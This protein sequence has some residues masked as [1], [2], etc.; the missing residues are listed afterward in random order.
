MSE[1]NENM[2]FYFHYKKRHNTKKEKITETSQNK[3]Y[4]KYENKC[5]RLS[6]HD[7][8]RGIDRDRGCNI[9]WNEVKILEHERLLYLLQQFTLLKELKHE[10]INSII[11]V[12]ISKER[13]IFMTE[14]W[15]GSS[16]RVILGKIG[17]QKKKVIKSWIIM[18]LKGLEY[19]HSKS[20]FYKYLNCGRLIYN[21]NSGNVS[22]GDLFL[23]TNNFI[24]QNEYKLTPFE[25]SCPAPEV[26]ENKNINE[27]AD[28]F[29]LGMVL[30][31]MVTL[32]LP[33]SSNLKNNNSKDRNNYQSLI[34][35]ITSGEKPLCLNKISD[36]EE[37]KN[38]IL[39]MINF[40][41]EERPSVSDLLNDKFLE[42]H[43]TKDLEVIKLK[44][45][46]KKQKKIKSETQAGVG[47][48][49]FHS[50]SDVE[51][52]NFLKY[53]VLQETEM[54]AN[55]K[56]K[57]YQENPFGVNSNYPCLYNDLKNKERNS[58]LN[59]TDVN[60]QNT[61][62][63]T[64]NKEESSLTNNI[65]TKSAEFSQDNNTMN[66]NNS[67]INTSN[68][69]NIQI[70]NFPT[71]NSYQNLPIYNNLLAKNTANKVNLLNNKPVYLRNSLSNNNINHNEKDLTKQN[72]ESSV[73]I[74][75]TSNINTNNSI[76][77]SPTPFLKK[78]SVL[79]NQINIYNGNN[80][81]NSLIFIKGIKPTQQDNS[82]YDKIQNLIVNPS[83][84]YN[85]QLLLKHENSEVLHRENN[86]ETNNNTNLTGSFRKSSLVAKE[87]IYTSLNNTKDISEIKIFNDKNEIT[88][89]F[90]IKES[91]IETD[92]EFEYNILKDTVEAIISEIKLEFNYSDNIIKMMEDHVRY[93]LCSVENYKYK[94]H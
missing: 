22:I 3:R 41:Q 61:F 8:Y 75:N 48:N 86:F 42:I 45:H 29:S 24:E 84:I 87:E 57:K 23:S 55:L 68:T 15:A 51:M 53:Y 59:F 62:T 38:F 33:Y 83:I 50:D 64:K 93:V 26:I 17:A 63:E 11:D 74:N 30:L 76:I 85:N 67:N 14:S 77:A 46:K 65:N 19:L 39:K 6:T 36:D 10:N 34:K 47:E 73:S 5:L 9:I 37:F 21:S 13:L 4:A 18:I 35:L 56:K 32:E 12:W 60:N 20:Y 66:I 79:S 43:K 40:N 94:L 89:K 31:E 16:I 90:K 54:K 1:E 28:I 52:K 70:K 58:K 88:F 82:N 80:S 44:K 2:Y 78:N 25:W 49:F 92:I 72:Y 71:V 69:V 91:N 7:S 27:K 81:A